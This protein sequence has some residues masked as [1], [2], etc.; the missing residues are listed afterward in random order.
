[1][2]SLPFYVATKDGVL[3][4]ERVQERPG[5]AQTLLALAERLLQLRPEEA[6]ASNDE[7]KRM[8]VDAVSTAVGVPQFALAVQ[9]SLFDVLRKAGYALFSKNWVLNFRLLQ[10]HRAA[11]REVYWLYDPKKRHRTRFQRDKPPETRSAFHRA[12]QEGDREKLKQLLKEDETKLRHIQE[13]KAQEA[14][15]RGHGDSYQKRHELRSQIEHVTS[16][17]TVRVDELGQEAIHLAAR[18]SDPQTFQTLVHMGRDPLHARDFLGRLPL[19]RAAESGD[20]VMVEA[21]VAFYRQEEILQELDKKQHSALDLAVLSGSVGAVEA[22]KIDASL[23]HVEKKRT[24]LHLAA[25]WNHVEVLKSLSSRGFA[26]DAVDSDQTRPLHLAARFGHSQ[27]V[28]QLIGLRANTAATTSFGR[29]ALHWAALNGHVTVTQQ[30]IA[31]G[32]PLDQRDHAGWTAFQWTLRRCH[33]PC[34]RTLIQGNAD[35]SLEDPKNQRNTLHIAACFNIEPQLLEELVE[36]LHSRTLADGDVAGK[37]PLHLSAQWGT[38]DVA[39]KLI[40]LK[41]DLE[42]RRSHQ[43]TPLYLSARRGN[44]ALVYELLRH[45]A[46]PSAL[47]ANGLAPIF[48]A[49]RQ[50][51]FRVVMLLLQHQASVT[52]T[53]KDGMTVLHWAAKHGNCQAIRALVAKCP[54]SAFHLVAALTNHGR[55][56]LHVACVAGRLE[57]SKVLLQLRSDP[58]LKQ[59]DGWMPIHLAARFGHLKVVDAL[60]ESGVDGEARGVYGKTAAHCAVQRAKLEMHSYQRSPSSNLDYFLQDQGGRNVWHLAALAGHKRYF[61][62]YTMME[63]NKDRKQILSLATQDAQGRT[64]LHLAAA[65]GKHLV[66]KA[67][68]ECLT[69]DS[70]KDNSYDPRWDKKER[71]PAISAKTADIMEL[72]NEESA[73]CPLLMLDHQ[74]R[75]PLHLAAMGGFAQVTSQLAKFMLQKLECSVQQLQLPDAHGDSPLKL[76]LDRKHWDAARR[77]VSSLALPSPPELRAVDAAAVRQ[78]PHG[79]AVRVREDF[80]VDAGAMRRQGEEGTLESVDDETVTIQFAG[81]LVTQTFSQFASCCVAERSY[82]LN[83]ST[84]KRRAKRPFP[85]LETR[86]E[87][88][89]GPMTL[90]ACA[91]TGGE[92]SEGDVTRGFDEGA[93]LRLPN[94]SYLPM[95]LQL[96]EARLVPALTLWHGPSLRRGQLVRTREELVKGRTSV[97]PNT[98]GLVRRIDEGDAA[99]VDFEGTD[100]WLRLPGKSFED[101]ELLPYVSVMEEPRTVPEEG[102]VALSSKRKECGQVEYE[103]SGT[104]SAVLFHLVYADG[105]KSIKLSDR[106][107][108][109][110]ISGAPSVAQLAHFVRRKEMAVAPVAP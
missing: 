24:P 75:S 26:V 84:W 67:I 87:A 76:A 82:L 29:S 33:A 32:C 74:G 51:H 53:E 73:P 12:A 59:K 86:C 48:A 85:A 92:F 49:A 100:R 5:L 70:D 68:L 80:A 102:I 61:N 95:L 27:A 31:R 103:G 2:L 9:S 50:D 110:E 46:D 15:L 65:K 23:L 107:G 62:V 40:Q 79:S 3:L 104:Y 105:S 36:T 34:S 66:V 38:V 56:A 35:L 37:T 25:Q 13:L 42:L 93:W 109:R 88:P 106:R 57:A 72:M 17:L 78:T 7:D 30:L 18:Y 55:S 96:D 1:M 47:D 60:L 81:E 11:S 71:H 52:S 89:T 20:P 98:V 91:N 41:S 16:Q 94:G 54:T 39:L 22:L 90:E 58:T 69:D 10:V 43:R 44:A 21:A 108:L 8:I 99:V 45:K 77:L 97:A 64:P 101:L 4:G 19:H 28:A 83:G 63:S 6:A 14:S